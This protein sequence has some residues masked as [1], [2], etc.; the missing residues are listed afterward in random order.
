MY[1][2]AGTNIIYSVLSNNVFSPLLF[3]CLYSFLQTIW[4]LLDTTTEES[5][6]TPSYMNF[7]LSLVKNSY[8]KLYLRFRF[9]WEHLSFSEEKKKKKIKN[10]DFIYSFNLILDIYTKDVWGRLR[11]CSV[12]KSNAPVRE[13]MGT[14]TDLY[15][16]SIDVLS[17][18]GKVYLSQLL[19]QKGVFFLQNTFKL[20]VMY[21]CI[22]VEMSQC[23][24]ESLLWTFESI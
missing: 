11:C 7:L 17:Q 8:W 13:S 12:D 24:Q 9:C 18:A 4:F 19:F 3:W 14:I 6:C 23:W 16:F 20:S 5:K 10:Q 15:V 1:T 21:Q 22:R 2:V